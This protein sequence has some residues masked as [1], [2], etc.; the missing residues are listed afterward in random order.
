MPNFLER[1]GMILKK[2]AVLP[3]AAAV[4]AVI[5]L[6][7]A[8]VLTAAPNDPLPTGSSAA[9]LPVVSLD[10]T[11]SSAIA[12]ALSGAASTFGIDQDSLQNVRLLLTNDVGTWYVIPGS[13]GVCLV[14]ID[15]RGSNPGA[16]GPTSSVNAGVVSLLIPDAAG[17]DYVGGG[18]YLTGHQLSISRGDG[19]SV[20]PSSI[21][22]GFAVSDAQGLSVSENPNVV[23]R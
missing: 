10:G 1:Q 7:A 2:K 9:Q 22:G 14:A 6:A 4:A 8:G 15:S 16:C 5:G 18:I 3:L 23:G 19:T 13:R 17:A 20:A 11:T 21:P 12:T